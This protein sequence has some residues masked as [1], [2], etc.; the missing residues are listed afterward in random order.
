MQ[1]HPRSRT[2]VGWCHVAALDTRYFR[3][4][5]LFW[6]PPARRAAFRRWLVHVLPCRRAAQRPDLFIERQPFGASSERHPRM[7]RFA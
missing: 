3:N 6:V 4:F 7:L 1:G 5:H 2:G